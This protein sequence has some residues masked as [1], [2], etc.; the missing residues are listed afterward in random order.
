MELRAVLSLEKLSP[1]KYGILEPDAGC[2]LV[3]ADQVEL[4][5]IPCAACSRDGRRLGRGGG[6]YDRFLSAY[7]GSAALVCRERLIR[8]EIPTEPLDIPVHWVVTEAGLYED[9]VPARLL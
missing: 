4:A 6:Y 3:A 7:R 2:P 5:V 1:G 9:G 8:E